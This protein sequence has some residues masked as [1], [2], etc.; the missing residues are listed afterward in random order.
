MAKVFITDDSSLTRDIL[1]EMVKE[2]GHTVIEASGGE[3]LLDSYEQEKPDVVFLDII[4]EDNGLEVLEKLKAM[5]ANAKVVICSAIGGMPHIVEEAK[6]KGA[7]T[8]LRK[9]FD[10]DAINHAIQLCLNE[11]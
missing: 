2:L 1:R 6:Q 3:A 11:A 4:M 10:R 8:C 5:D 7:V 9:P